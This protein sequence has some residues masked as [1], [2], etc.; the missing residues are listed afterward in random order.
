LNVYIPTSAAVG[1]EEEGKGEEAG[2]EGEDGEVETAAAA[3][4][5]VTP[6]GCQIGCN[7]D[8]TG[9]HHLD[10]FGHTPYWGWHSRVSDRLVTW[11]VP[12]VINWCS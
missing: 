3:R 8:H 4:R 11:T 6:G 1:S 9:C 12:A 2:S 7:V 5:V 10:V